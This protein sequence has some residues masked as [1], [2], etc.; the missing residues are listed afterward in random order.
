M[1]RFARLLPVVA[2]VAAGCA[3]D[4]ARSLLPVDIV[5]GPEVGAIAK[6]DLT[7]SLGVDPVVTRTLTW[8]APAG[9]PL[10]VGL[11]LPHAVSG[12]VNVQAVALDGN[13]S[14]LGASDM[15]P[16]VIHPGK[17]ADL[18]TL[19]ITPRTSVASDGGAPD[20]GGADGPAGGP[21]LDGGAL[22]ADGPDGAVTDT[23]P[24]RDGALDQGLDRGPDAAGPPSFSPPENLEPTDMVSPSYSPVVAVD[25]QG[26]TLVAWEEDSEVKSRR[27]DATAK[28]W[29]DT[30]VVE[31]RG[32]IES[33]ILKMA[34]N[35][36]ATL[37]WRQ[38]TG[39]D[40]DPLIGVWASHSKDGG[41]MWTPPKQVHAGASFGNVELAVSRD[42]S[43]RAAWAETVSNIYSLWAARYED[44]TGLWSDVAVVKPGTDSY[45]RRPRI[46][47]DGTGGGIMVWTQPDDM[48][49]TSTWGTSFAANGPLKTP[50]VL[51]TITTD[52]TYDPVVAISPDGSK[53]IALWSQLATGGSDVYSADYT[54]A[55][56]WQPAARAIVKAYFGWPVVVMDQTA[57][58]TVAYYES[59]TSGAVNIVAARRAWGQPW[60]QVTPL[61]NTNKATLKV[62]EVPVPDIGLDASGNVHV[63]W[64]RK[65]STSDENTYSIVTRRWSMGAWQPEQ[66]LFTKDKMHANPPSV[67]VGEN[68]QAA[69]VFSYWDPS[70]SGD[71]NSHSAFAALFLP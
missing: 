26:N 64:D 40:K 50:Q 65:N 52:S 51:D 47:M 68:G 48:M 28:T 37:M 32:G 49:Q 63:A 57:T 56:G 3:N 23:A 24:V 38:Q 18:L 46:A 60:G 45:D 58:V 33:I 31:S 66:I 19:T 5:A 1:N 62:E 67:G 8:D 36:H 70:S 25:G 12:T 35:G 41:L 13:G 11:Y 55:G 30:K 34:P 22:A 4:S 61:E 59:L 16:A 10:K 27:W 54:P 7:A 69:I 15:V 9:Q 6:V 14:I 20:G 42:G 17:Q 2:L 21:D 29:S 71:P 43:A 39:V 53:G 44:A